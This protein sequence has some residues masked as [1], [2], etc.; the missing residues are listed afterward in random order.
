MRHVTAAGSVDTPCATERHLIEAAQALQRLRA[1]MDRARAMP[2]LP[3]PSR[4]R[5]VLEDCLQA[6]RARRQAR[7][8]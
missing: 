4:N 5:V 8:R 3:E 2:P 6:S 1:F 7:M